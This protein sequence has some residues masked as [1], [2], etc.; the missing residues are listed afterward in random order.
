[1]VRK[2]SKKIEQELEEEMIEEKKEIPQIRKRSRPI[3]RTP[4]SFKM[5]QKFTWKNSLIALIILI[6]VVVAAWKILSDSDESEEKNLE[7]Y[8]VKI[9]CLNS[10]HEVDGGNF[11]NY[12]IIGKNMGKA[13][14][15]IKLSSFGK[16]K[17]WEVQFDKNNIKLKPKKSFVSILNITVPS[18]HFGKSFPLSVTASSK[19][20]PSKEDSINIIVNITSLTG[21]RIK[22]GDEISVDYIGCLETN[23]TIF[24]TSVEIVGKNDNLSFTKDLN[25][26]RNQKDYSRDLD[27]T[28]GKG[29]MIEGFDEAVV[30]MKVGDTKVVRIPP[31]KAYG[32]DPNNWLGRETLIFEITLQSTK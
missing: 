20:N 26:R 25:E 24:D 21:E 32:K 19:T 28:V 10:Q 27:F 14:D 29:Q 12:I 2:R 9:T 3:K 17:D 15:T 11:T 8:G 5:K 4:I 6:I 30:G 18:S 13:S 1:M 16:Q 22:N 23:G 7:D 31:E